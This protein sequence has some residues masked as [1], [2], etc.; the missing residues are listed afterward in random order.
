[1]AD[2]FTIATAAASAVGSIVE[3]IGGYQANKANAKIAEQNRADVLNQ[4]NAQEAD[5]RAQGTQLEGAQIAATGA[6]GVTLQG[7]PTD[8]IM[9]SKVKSELDALRVRYGAQ[10]Q[11]TGY[12]NQANAY[13]LAARQSLTGGIIAGLAAP[14]LKGLASKTVSGQVNANGFGVKL[15]GA[16]AVDTSYGSPNFAGIY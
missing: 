14:S 12:R 15:P 13:K 7:S 2:P 11:A 16:G 9:D 3:G 8:V 4:G 10:V 6:S 5:V 1:M